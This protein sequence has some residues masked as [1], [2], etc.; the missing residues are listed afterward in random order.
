MS[1]TSDFINGMNYGRLYNSVE[2]KLPFSSSFKNELKEDVVS[3]LVENNY[4]FSFQQWDEVWS[5][6][7]CTPNPNYPKQP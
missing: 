7:Q 2:L 4:S 6:L 1:K 5:V 3:L